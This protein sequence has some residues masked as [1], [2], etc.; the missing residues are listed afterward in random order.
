MGDRTGSRFDLPAI[1]RV[2][3]IDLRL[4]AKNNVSLLLDE[5]FSR[6][7][8][9]ITKTPGVV[10]VLIKASETEALTS[11]IY[12]MEY[13][14]NLLE[15]IGCDSF[16]HEISEIS[17]ACKRGHQ[18]FATEQLRKLLDKINE[19]HAKIAAAEKKE[20]PAGDDQN[21]EGKDKKAPAAQTLY[22]ALEQL[23]LEESTRKMR[24]LAVDDAPVVLKT[25][26]SLLGDE[27]KIYGMTDPKKVEG[28]LKQITPDLFLLDYKMPEISGFDLVPII[29]SFNEHKNTPII[30]LTSMGTVDY[31]SAAFALGA[32]D[33]IV[34][35][36]QGNILR[37]KVAK[38]IVRK[39]LF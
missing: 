3:G 30:F 10:E 22:M 32:A 27:Y 36:F 18:K 7:S 4:L 31:V 20:S 16:T 14:R 8:K 9:F 35:P 19:F 6:L 37:E 5:Y 21:N 28:F 26:S 1:L 17:K 29:R 33:F 39:K 11:D 12:R 2:G 13:I 25:I 38:H 24:I 23:D 15:D 34:K